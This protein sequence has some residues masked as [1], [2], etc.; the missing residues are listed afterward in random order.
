[1]EVL[2]TRRNR[3]RGVARSLCLIV[4]V[5]AALAPPVRLCADQVRTKGGTVYEGSVVR[6]EGDEV[7]I[8]TSKGTIRLSRKDIAAIRAMEQQTDWPKRPPDAPKI[9]PVVV[10]PEK[11][12]ETLARA[13]EAV[14]AGKWVEAGGLLEGLADLKGEVLSVDDRRGVISSLATCYLQIDD[15]RGAARSFGRRAMVAKDDDQ[16]RRILAAAE[17]LDAAKSTR[18]GGQAVRTYQEAVSAAVR[19]KVDQIVGTARKMTG[20][21]RLVTV[22]GRLDRTARAALAKLKEADLYEP[23][24]SARQ[25]SSVLR[26]L[27]DA[28]MEPVRKA[29][30]TCSRERQWF[31]A[32]RWRSLSDKETVKGWTQRIA[33]Y[34]ALRQGAEEGLKNLKAF[35]SRFD[36]GGL[37]N[38]REV[39]RLLEQ[40]EDLK[41]YPPRGGKRIKILPRRTGGAIKR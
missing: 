38:G 39:D 34:L 23:G 13:R 40:L 8:E 12:R 28:V 2:R 19:W 27:V 37:Y 14:K 10:T 30:S 26:G 4:V 31:D 25:R 11:A 33:A 16:R 32:N 15:A 22:R 41:Y 9:T 35:A 20:K 36:L 24:T 21:A 5:A 6:Q 1:L 7:V 18:I 29:V 17:A 3:R